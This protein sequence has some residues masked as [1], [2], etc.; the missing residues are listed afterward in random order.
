MTPVLFYPFTIDLFL[1]GGP[2]IPTTRC[3]TRGDWGLHFTR[4]Q[5]LI[6]QLSGIDGHNVVTPV[7]FAGQQSP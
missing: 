6:A 2:W 4:T 1:V 7:G 3:L 5:Q